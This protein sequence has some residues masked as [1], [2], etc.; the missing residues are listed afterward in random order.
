[1]VACKLAVSPKEEC[2]DIIPHGGIL[3]LTSAPGTF[4]SACGGMTS[5]MT[6][7][8]TAG[9]G[10]LLH[11]VA[12]AT[13]HTCE[14]LWWHDI[15][16]GRTINGWLL[17]AVA[18]ATR[19]TCECL[20]WHD[21]GHGHTNH[22]LAMARCCMRLM[23]LHMQPGTLE[24]ACGGMTSVMATPIKAWLWL[25]VACGCAC[26]LAHLRMPVVA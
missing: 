17:Q 2:R 19:H 18:H 14:C 21:I 12:H 13:W 16:H 25:A 8:I 9:C 26:N 10:M 3:L 11:A 1:M 22:S 15:G 4:L 5:V 24:S 6:T 23:R 20:W 7:P